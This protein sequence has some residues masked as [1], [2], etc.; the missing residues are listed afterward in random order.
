M[1]NTT[2]LS[3]MMRPVFGDHPTEWARSKSL[4]MLRRATA[5]RIQNVADHFYG[6]PREVW[7]PEADIPACVPPWPVCWAEYEQPRFSNNEGV[8]VDMGAGHLGNR[9]RFGLLC[10]TVGGAGSGWLLDLSTWMMGS[11]LLFVGG[12]I[13]VLDPRGVTKSTAGVPMFTHPR[14]GKDDSGGLSSLVQIPADILSL[15]FA[16]CHC[17]NVSVVQDD[18][19]APGVLHK[20]KSN[21]HVPYVR[22]N[23]L[24]IGGLGAAR[25]VKRQDQ[26]GGSIE[27]ALHICR[28][29]FAEYGDERP[30][31]GKYAGRFWVPQH[32]RGTPGRGV[33][34]KDYE[35]EPQAGE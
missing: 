12:H 23:S 2:M 4:P 33:V 25:T 9:P 3:R 16:F 5:V 29:H 30:L 20:L 35:V 28:G 14:F 10:V 27:R 11:S 15:A 26:D 19:P 31:F 7:A 18:L 8:V 24:R 6:S 22:W 13:R 1:S 17:K 21:R 32:T 34:L